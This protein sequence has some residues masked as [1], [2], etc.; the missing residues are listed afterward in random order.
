MGNPG[1]LND[2]NILDRSPL[3]QQLFYG[4]VP[5]VSFQVN[6][7]QY[8]TPY[9]LADGIYPRRTS[10]V[11]AYAQPVSDVD[12][13][14]TYWQESVRKDIERAFGVLQ[15]RW[16]MLAMPARQWDWSLLDNMVRCCVILH[17]MIIEDEYEMEEIDE[18]YEYDEIDGTVVSPTARIEVEDLLM[19]PANSPFATVLER[20]A[21][22][23]NKAMHFRLREDLKHHL[24]QNHVH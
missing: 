19:D 6:G 20:I 1:S 12:C 22:H 24:F 4:T 10:F 5:K 11:L 8:D 7:N 18:Q 3:L 16:R 14:F 23:Q 9:W 15:A 17:N 13:N 2:L 21:A